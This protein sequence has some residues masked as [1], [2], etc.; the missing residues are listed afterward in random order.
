MQW[1]TAHHLISGMHRLSIGQG[2]TSIVHRD[3]LMFRFVVCLAPRSGLGLGLGT[4]EPTTE[5]LGFARRALLPTKGLLGLTKG[6]LGATKRVLDPTRR[7]L[8]PT[9]IG[10]GPTKR[11]ILWPLGTTTNVGLTRGALGP[12]R[13]ANQRAQPLCFLNEQLEQPKWLL[14]WKSTWVNQRGTWTEQMGI[15]VYQWGTWANYKGTQANQRGNWAEQ[16]GT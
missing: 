9:K 12:T 7:G 16:R 15:Y 14:S 3:R 11:E 10:S 2:G 6:E 5:A 8:R 1:S 4:L 13:S